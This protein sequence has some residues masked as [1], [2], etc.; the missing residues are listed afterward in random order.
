VRWLFTLTMFLGSG[1]LFLIQPIVGK[2]ALPSFGGTPAV[3]NTSLLFFQALLLA[4][5]AY[6]H[7]SLRWLGPRMQPWAHVALFAA[8]ILLT[9]PLAV[10]GV[11][12][13]LAVSNPVPYL[14]ATLAAAVGPL[15][16]VISAGAPLVQRWFSQTDDPAAK[17]PYFLYAASNAGSLVG[18]LSYPFVIEPRLRISQQADLVTALAVAVAV[19]LAACALVLRGRPGTSTAAPED[20]EAPSPRQRAR[21]VLLAAVPSSLLMSVT[22]YLTTD[23]APVPLLWVVPLALYLVTFI[24]AFSARNTLKPVIAARF[25]PVLV[26]PLLLVLVLE[27]TS[28]LVPLAALHL[29]AFTVVALALHTALASERPGPAR[30]TEFYLWVSLGGVLGGMVNTVVAPLVFP[31]L[32]EY[33]LGLVAACALLAARPGKEGFVRADWVYPVTVG[34]ATLVLIS[35][36]RRLGMEPGGPRTALTIGVPAVL[37]F[38]ASGRPYRFAG[39]VLAVLAASH[40]MGTVMVGRNLEVTRSFF[41]VHRVMVTADRERRMLL[42]GNT[43]HGQ[44]SLLP[45]HRDKPLTYYY[46]TGPIGQ[47][48]T[49]LNRTGRLRKAAMVG[50]GVGSLAAYGKPGQSFTFYEI[51]PTVVRLARDSGWFDFLAT[52]QADVR[53]VLGDARLTL[54]QATDRYDLLV[55]DAFSSDSVPIHLITR[56]AIKLDFNRLEPEGLLAVHI[57]N[58][59]LDLA[60]VLA[61]I[62]ADLGLEAW[63]NQDAY[64]L[65]EESAIGKFASTWVVLA[66]DEAALGELARHRDWSTLDTEPGKP[67]WTDD[68][69]PVFSALRD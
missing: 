21:W 36:A 14:L 15:F 31:G 28:P 56:E 1:L 3:W 45:E 38:L 68:Y 48:F 57:S 51:D 50:L 41:G 27:S 16:F 64:V 6:A 66:R 42:H 55:V 32:F 9:V 39:S 13:E 54:A 4:G 7:Y 5:Y 10:R 65:P 23:L 2:M 69:A 35:V 11:S 25:V 49:E 30:L 43:I 67:V 17:D 46:Q 24:V 44:Q 63:I 58:R 34:L 22:T 29:A 40:F 33:P 52:S 26:T 61:A 8:A 53:I 12:P 47:V 62:A 20:F 18:L 60:P 37:A 19:L 59:Y